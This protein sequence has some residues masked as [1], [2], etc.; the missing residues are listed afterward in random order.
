MAYVLK[1]QL[2]VK[3]PESLFIFVDSK[4]AQEHITKTE[5]LIDALTCLQQRDLDALM[6]EGYREMAEEGRRL[7]EASLFAAAETLHEW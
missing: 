2:S 6:A 1:K 5:V 3:L 4:A 7:A